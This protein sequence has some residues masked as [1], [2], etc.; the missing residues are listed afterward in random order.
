MLWRSHLLLWRSQFLGVPRNWAFPYGL[1]AAPGH[2]Q[3]ALGTKEEAR[4]WGGPEWGPRATFFAP[5]ANWP[6][7]GA[8]AS[9]WERPDGER[10]VTDAITLNVNAVTL[11]GNAEVGWGGV[12]RNDYKER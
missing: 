9:P 4:P 11:N 3:V 5:S 8:A 7:P 6:W 10:P 12:F 2:G 1:V